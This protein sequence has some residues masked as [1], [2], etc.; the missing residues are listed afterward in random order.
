MRRVRRRNKEIRTIQDLPF[1]IF[2]FVRQYLIDFDVKRAALEAGYKP[3]NAREQGDGLLRHPDVQRVMQMEMEERLK[4]SRRNEDD[5][6]RDIQDVGKEAR[7][8]GDLKSCLRAL[9]LEGKHY[10]MF[11]EKV[12]NEISGTLDVR[13]EE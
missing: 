7:E 12:Q 2:E 6:L 8:K 1:Q 4:E 5:V 3:A 10:C 9:E 13:W 11:T